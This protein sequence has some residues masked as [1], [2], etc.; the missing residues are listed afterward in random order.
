MGTNNCGFSTFPIKKKWL[1][2]YVK[3]VVS[4]FVIQLDCCVVYF[5]EKEMTEIL[6]VWQF[7]GSYRTEKNWKHLKF[8]SVPLLSYQGMLPC[9]TACLPWPISFINTERRSV[10][11]GLSF[12][13][14]HWKSVERI[15][16]WPYTHS[17][18]RT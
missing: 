5:W 12:F 13:L 6:N 8:P 9:F 18:T 1:C 2:R 17:L 15:I 3:D 10:L 7:L 4:S 11:D 14:Y 16:K